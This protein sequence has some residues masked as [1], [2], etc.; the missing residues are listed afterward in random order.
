MALQISNI[1]CKNIL[2]I[3]QGGGGLGFPY[4]QKYYKAV[5]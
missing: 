2:H 4:L 3:D 5:I 1:L